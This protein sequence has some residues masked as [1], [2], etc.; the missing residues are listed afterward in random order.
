M[1]DIIPQ[2]FILQQASKII[3]FQTDEIKCI[4]CS[5]SYDES[6]L[7]D[8][9]TLADV[10]AN[11]I[12]AGNGYVTGGITVSGTSAYN[13]DANN[14]TIYKCEDLYFTTSSGNIGPTRYAVMYDPDGSDTII[15]VFDFGEDKTALD[16]SNLV[17]KVDTTGFMKAYQL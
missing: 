12:L 1:A 14:R 13:D 8:F 6:A 7:R 5:G 10:S 17:I 2:Y 15:Y 16:G 4:L 9:Q 11:E 3:D